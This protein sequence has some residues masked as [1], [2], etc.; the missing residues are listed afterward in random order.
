[1]CGIFGFHAVDASTPAELE[2][3]RSMGEAIRHRGPDDEGYFLERPVGLGMRRLSIIDLKTGRQPIHNED[4]SLHVVFNGEIYNYRELMRDLLARGHT[5]YTSTDTEVIV[6]LYEEFGRDC[7]HRLRGMFAFALWDRRAGT[8]FIARDRLGIKPLYYAE[9]A[10]GLVFGSELKALLRVPGLSREVDL[11]AL[12]AYLRLG[13]VP[14]PLSILRG[15]F[16]LPPGHWLE[17]RRDG[18]VEVK[19]YWDPAPFFE[20][21]RAPRSEEALLEELRWRL[22]EAVKLHLVSDVPLGAFL[23]GG[24]DSSTVVALMASELGG[25]VKTFSIGFGEPEFNELP[26]A[27]VVAERVGAE[28][29]EFVVG[30]ESVDLI[31]HIIRYFD[32]PFADA[33]AIPTYLVSKLAAEHVKV[34]LS[35]DGGD[36]LFAGYDRYVVDHRRR[37]TDVIGRLGMSGVLRSV[38]E[39]LPEGARGKNYL[40]NSS[41]PRMER[42]IDSISHHRPRGLERLLSRDVVAELHDCGS[43]VLAPH[44]ARGAGLDFPS[45]LQYVDMKSYL[46]GDILTKVDRMSMAHSIEARVPLLD[47]ELVEFVAAVPSRH[48]LRRGATKYLLKRAIQGLVPPEIV[49]R[50]KQGF[51]IPVEHWFRGEL[52]NVLQE[53]LLSSDALRHGLFDRAYVEALWASYVGTTRGDVLDRLWGLLVF[54]VWHHTF[55]GAR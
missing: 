37:H 7:V 24:I 6:H 43:E 55:I 3:L 29:H 30:P 50:K 2:L 41:L 33:S 47:H 54:E 12:G 11:T 35:G 32:E 44:I 20:E 27:R 42:Y 46:P 10:G 28:H 17:R 34:V 4:G 48:K 38:S 36:E 52:R 22:A 23:S 39:A 19:P 18:T 40:F 13:Y 53:R 8:L 45:R 9:T 25:R 51:G 21:T 14:D 16:K 5:F 1:V 15:V 49:L 31:E 26:Y